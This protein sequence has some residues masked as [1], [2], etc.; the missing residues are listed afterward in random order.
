MKRV[1]RKMKNLWSV[2]TECQKVHLLVICKYRTKIHFL[3]VKIKK[4]I[5]V[6]VNTYIQFEPYVF[7]GS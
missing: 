6:I 1:R 7:C 2:I 3:E 5:G 4:I